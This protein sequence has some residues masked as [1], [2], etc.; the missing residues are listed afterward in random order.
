MKIVF[1][2]KNRYQLIKIQWI[3]ILENRINNIGLE[4]FEN[5]R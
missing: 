1:A 3:K 4:K 2:I 5:F